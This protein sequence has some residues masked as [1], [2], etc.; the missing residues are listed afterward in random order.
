MNP[1]EDNKNLRRC[2]ICRER[3]IYYN[4]SIGK[5]RIE[6]CCNC[7]LMR[8]NPQPTN[9]D[10]T[11]F[12]KNN[13]IDNPFSF[14]E[15]YISSIESYISNP[16]E[17]KMLQ[18]GSADFHCIA[19]AKDL[20]VKKLMTTKELSEADYEEVLNSKIQAL[21]NS[22]ESFDFIL[23]VNVLN[24]V[25]H[26]RLFLR[27]IRSLLKESGIV[28]TILP[29]VD[30]LTARLMKSRWAGFSLQNLWYFSK[31][32]LNQLFH[33]EFF[34]ELKLNPIKEPI[35]LDYLYQNLSR[36]SKQPFSSLI[37]YTRFLPKFIR[38]Y[39]FHFAT[40]NVMLFAK[41]KPINSSKKLSVVMPAFN[42]ANFVKNVID[43]ILAK[44]IDGIEMELIIVESN[45]TD[46][47]REI[48]K[49]YEGKERIT[50]IWQDTPR[51]KG[52]AVR[53]G[54]EKV[55]GDYI[56]IQDADT[57]YDIEDYDAL[58]EPLVT[59]EATFVLGARHGGGAWKM[60]Q[61][62]DQRLTGHL[63]NMGHWFFAA[64]V[65]LTYGL[66]LK[67]PFTM[68]KVFRADC[69]RGIK[70]ECN[71]FDFDYELLIKLVKHGHYPIEIP[72]NYRSRSFK[73]GKKVNVLR[74]PWTWLVAIMKY[75]FQQI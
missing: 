67:D 10:L 54:L 12:N 75:K 41:N 40:S 65:N 3:K 47:T 69:L 44:K 7:S 11:D 74:D 16:L 15:H 29:T 73:E 18:I 38:K 52:N 39:Q 36:Y 32:T 42:E 26:P 28:V 13:Q 6:K 58:V 8:L 70:L 63:L 57:E 2:L 62:E 61:F 24:R 60:R 27:N 21:Q 49:Q 31:K 53:A 1:L 35:N 46:G 51:G 22:S 9:Q 5:F 23:L 30:S 43:S 56:L 37:K 68:Y 59:G 19:T 17:G 66:K 25:R 64:L 48:V 14:D 72:V 20:A 34:E 71:R 50:I 4:F 33:D 55:S 45:S